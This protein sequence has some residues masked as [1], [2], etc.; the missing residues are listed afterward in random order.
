LE[1]YAERATVIKL[2]N[3]SALTILCLLKE[4]TALN[5]FVNSTKP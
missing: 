1:L 5:D 4:K 3:F 2:R